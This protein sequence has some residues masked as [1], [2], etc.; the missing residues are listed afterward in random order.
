MTKIIAGRYHGTESI[1]SVILKRSSSNSLLVFSL[2]SLAPKKPAAVL[3][4]YIRWPQGEAPMARIWSIPTITIEESRLPVHGHEWTILEAAPSSQL[5][6]PDDIAPVDIL[7]T[8]SWETINQ[9][10]PSKPQ[11]NPWP[12][13][14][15]IINA[16]CLQS[17]SFRGNLL[18]SN[19]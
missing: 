15:K 17:L 1:T 2:R 14:T 5:R 18:C 10:Q 13:E 12:T 3:R 6:P 9:N 7:T 11:P 16:C 4:R 19:R 8:D